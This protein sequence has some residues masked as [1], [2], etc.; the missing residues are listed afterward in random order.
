MILNSYSSNALVT[1]KALII[2]APGKGKYFLEGVLADVNNYKSFLKSGIGGNWFDHEIEQLI[3]PKANDLQ[4]KLNNTNTDYSFIVFAGHGGYKREDGKDYLEINDDEFFEA[5][6]LRTNSKRQTIIVDSCRTQMALL[7]SMGKSLTLESGGDSA[8]KRSLFDAHL[9]KCEEGIIRI[10]STSKDQAA[11]ED[12]DG[13][14]FSSSLIKVSTD[15]ANARNSGDNILDIKDAFD[16]A[17]IKMEDVTHIQKPEIN[18]G[19]RNYFFPFAIHK[20]P[21]NNK[22]Y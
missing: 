13:G 3:N 19:R 5:L 18:P 21:V 14:L 11:E 4:I 7:N 15:W 17:C 6:R 10:F 2:A 8:Q 22:Q 16:L 12:K 1:R 9:M 20:N